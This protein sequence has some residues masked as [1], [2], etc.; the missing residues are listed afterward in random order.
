MACIL[1]CSLLCSVPYPALFMGP[2][3]TSKTV[4]YPHCFFLY[5]TWLWPDPLFLFS[6]PPPSINLPCK[7]QDLW[8]DFTRGG[9]TVSVYYLRYS[10]RHC[11]IYVPALWVVT[12]MIY[13]YVWY[14]WFHYVPI[15][16]SVYVHYQ[17][18]NKV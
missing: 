16:R 18:S 17:N 10:V 8:T 6:G 13:I 4:L 9:A 15:L 5:L 1:Y 11:K 3:F 12:D 7:Y 2:F 14:V